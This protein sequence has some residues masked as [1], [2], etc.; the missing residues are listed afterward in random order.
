MCVYLVVSE[1]VPSGFISFVAFSTCA[2]DVLR[3]TRGVNRRVVFHIVF[4][5]SLGSLLTILWGLV[6][7]KLWLVLGLH[8]FRRLLWVIG[9]VATLALLPP[10]FPNAAA[11]GLSL[12]LI[13]AELVLLGINLVLFGLVHLA[14]FLNK[15][16]LP[17]WFQRGRIMAGLREKGGGVRRSSL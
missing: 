9:V 2:D 13:A 16:I 17:H 15:Y 5:S 12:A 6:A 1:R 14:V 8:V 4:Y 11:H 10:S 7:W 3:P